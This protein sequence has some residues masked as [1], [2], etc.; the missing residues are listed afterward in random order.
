MSSVCLNVTDNVTVNR[1]RWLAWQI[2]FFFPVVVMVIAR[3]LY[4]EPP[5][6]LWQTVSGVLLLALVLTG[7]VTDLLWHKIPN[8]VTYTAFIWGLGINAIAAVSNETTAGILGA[9]G[10][11][12][13]FAGAFLPFFF[14][15]IIF[16]VTG[17]GAGDVK[18][19]AAMGALLGLDRVIQ[20]ILLSFVFAGGVA[21]IRAVWLQGPRNMAVIIYRW[22]GNWLFPL[23]ILPLSDE[24]RAFLRQPMPLGPSFAFGGILV[25]FN[26]N[27]EHLMDVIVSMVGGS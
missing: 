20:A 12:D 9:V 2:A 23:W 4:R 10:I 17:G 26:V 5:E 21:L 16:S 6:F 19:T 24:Q 11:R 1:F 25:L 14:M 27:V 22:I 15:L 8:W 18:L 7:A 13:C 3:L